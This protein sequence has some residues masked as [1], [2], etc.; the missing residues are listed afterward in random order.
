MSAERTEAVAIAG[1][2][3]AGQAGQAEGGSR[4][5]AAV[6]RL[7]RARGLAAGTPHPKVAAQ[8]AGQCGSSLIRAYRL[9]LGIALADV[10]AQVRARYEADGR[11]V[12]RFSET[13][14]SAYESGQKRPGAEYLHY[15]CAT[16]QADPAD[17]GFDG[18]C[19]CGGSHRPRPVPAPGGAA[20]RPGSGSGR[21]GGGSGGP[22]AAPGGQAAVPG[23]GPLAAAA[24]LSAGCCAI[25]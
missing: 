17:L 22:A 1:E 3:E 24:R 21:P 11:S 16:Y 12:P 14:L 23:P 5:E 18:S 8:I 13:L 15:L 4:P 7:I 20:G 10:V 19:L 25:G 6:A 9:A 2:T